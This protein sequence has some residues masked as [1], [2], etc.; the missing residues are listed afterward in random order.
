MNAYDTGF[1]PPALCAEVTIAN[2]LN[3]RKR[4]MGKALFDTGADI[5]AASGRSSTCPTISCAG[6]VY[7]SQR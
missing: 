6:A 3:R 5:T 1:D 2:S 4:R 7:A